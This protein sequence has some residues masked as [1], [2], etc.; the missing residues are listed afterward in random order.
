[1]AVGNIAYGGKHFVKVVVDCSVIPRLYN[2]LSNSDEIIR[3]RAC[4]IAS[5]IAAGN[6]AEVLALINKNIVPKVI[7]LLD[8]TSLH[9]QR[10]AV[11]TI[12]QLTG[13]VD[14]TREQTRFVADQGWVEPLCCSVLGSEDVELLQMA[15][16]ALCDLLDRLGKKKGQGKPDRYS[17]AIKACGGLDKIKSLQSHTDNLIGRR[18]RDIMANYFETEEDA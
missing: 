9:I 18:A 13:A 6:R 15:L 3:K 2:L 10:G 11:W 5:V 4:W 7:D 16:R 1:M 8:D 17:A 14:A 12:V